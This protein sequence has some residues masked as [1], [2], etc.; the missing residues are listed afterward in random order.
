MAIRI[1]VRSDEHYLAHP[2]FEYDPY[3]CAHG[4]WNG[5]R[6][7]QKATLPLA[8]IQEQPGD[9]WASFG[10]YALPNPLDTNMDDEMFILTLY[11][12]T[13]PTGVDDLD[14]AESKSVDRNINSGETTF[15]L[16]TLLTTPLPKEGYHLA[17]GTLYLVE[18]DV[19]MNAL[20][21]FGK[22]NPE[23][24]HDVVGALGEARV[25][26]IETDA[27]K[28]S[29]KVVFK[30]KYEI[31][32]QTAVDEYLARTPTLTSRRLY[33][34]AKVREES[35]SIVRELEDVTVRRFSDVSIEENASM[36]KLKRGERIA[37]NPNEPI[38]K[39]LHLIR[40][41][42]PFG[43]QLPLAWSRQD[44]TLRHGNTRDGVNMLAE[45]GH[46]HVETVPVLNNML[47]QLVSALL[48]H[49]MNVDTFLHVVD[50]QFKET[51]SDLHAAFLTAARAVVD[52]ATFTANRILY[53]GDLAYPNMY[54]LERLPR[55]KQRMYAPH[56]FPTEGE[57]DVIAETAHVTSPQSRRSKSR[58]QIKHLQKSW[59]YHCQLHH[60]RGRQPASRGR[61]PFHVDITSASSRFD[62]G[63]L[64]GMGSGRPTSSEK[65]ELLQRQLT[66]LR[67]RMRADVTLMGRQHV[68]FQRS[69][70]TAVKAEPLKSPF[71]NAIEHRAMV[72]SD[73]FDTAQYAG[74]TNSGDCDKGGFGIPA[75]LYFMER[76]LE[77]A[78]IQDQ[79]LY[80]PLLAA[81]RILSLYTPMMAGASA[82]QPNLKQEVVTPSKSS[83][84]SKAPRPIFHPEL[85]VIG[86]E[87]D[88]ALQENGHAYGVIMPRV[89][90]LQRLLKSLTTPEGRMKD[91]REQM[92]VQSQVL[93]ELADHKRPWEQYLEVLIAEG[94]GPTSK[95]ILPLEEIY[96]KTIDGEAYVRKGEATITFIRQLKSYATPEHAAV[97]DIAR[98]HQQTYEVHALPSPEH[99]VSF[100][101]K[102]ALHLISPWLAD[103]FGGHMGHLVACMYDNGGKQWVRG[104]DMGRFCRYG[105]DRE[106][107]MFVPAYGMH[108]TRSEWTQRIDPYVNCILN[109]QPMSTWSRDLN[110]DP[111]SQLLATSKLVRLATSSAV[112]L[113]SETEL[114]GR[115]NTDFPPVPR[116][117]HND[118]TGFGFPRD[119]QRAYTVIASGDASENVAILPLE[120]SPWK[121]VA[122]QGHDF[123][124]LLG[125]LK[126]LQARG[127]IKYALFLRDQPLS[128]CSPCI[129]VLLALPAGEAV[130]ARKAL[131]SHAYDS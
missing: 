100:F 12:K 28:L 101:Y 23:I 1:L 102:A 19:M 62:K 98:P 83:E 35:L 91:Q 55:E 60:E 95:S 58:R 17:F 50:T 130:P 37:G 41:D 120:I 92:R 125:A 36:S 107:V 22:D 72:A 80:A 65:H 6:T 117:L 122:N 26:E 126:T 123:Q 74:E 32:D 70:K 54:Y 38:V 75:T 112:S 47:K 116:A 13:Q 40:N 53:E 129:Q 34:D 15:N 44:G 29:T 63:I 85:P 16:R 25:R 77:E 114:I 2:P 39:N 76:F 79:G 97:I 81:K 9:E 84:G 89:A 45:A 27:I 67:Q 106:Q 87:V 10:P 96:H 46:L 71:A 57:G 73:R 56:L 109:L 119:D 51:G 121:L 64:E 111:Q 68:A 108:F 88:Q 113:R 20:Q 94:T 90:V 61:R 104:V 131:T 66:Q 99:R 128:Q 24:F 59:T 52:V 48:R 69:E 30:I 110:R 78:P 42:T 86:S 14:I 127:V 93:A 4:S 124:R 11:S 8:H 18:R 7:T 31:L 115:L 3:L 43:P 103:K 49:G 33:S 118:P 82:T 105:Q 21:F 5:A